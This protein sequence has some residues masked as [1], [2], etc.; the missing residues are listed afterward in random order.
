MHPVHQQGQQNVVGRQVRGRNCYPA[1]RISA[2]TCRM[3]AHCRQHF[4][5]NR[6]GLI[7]LVLLLAATAATAQPAPDAAE[8]YGG[9]IEEHAIKVD[10]SE[11]LQ[12][13]FEAVG[14]RRFVLL[15][16]SSHGT[17]EFYVWRDRITR[18]LVANKGFDFVAV[19]GDWQAI[20]RLNDYVTLR[21][22]HDNGVAGVMLESNSWP[23]WLWANEEFAAF[24]EW[25][26][27]HN[28]ALEPEQRVGLYGLDLQDPEDSARSVLAWFEQR[29]G[30]D[31]ERI[32]A[33]YRHFLDLPGSFHG[34]A[35][36]LAGGGERLADQAG[37]A[38]ELLNSDTDD[39]TQEHWQARHNAIAVARFERYIHDTMRMGATAGWNRR[40]EHFHQTLLALAERY[41]KQ[42]RA[43]V[44]AH[45]THI[46]DARATPMHGQGQ[47]NIG[48]LLRQGEGE[49]QVFI[50]G[51]STHGGKVMAARRDGAQ[52]EIFE[53]PAAR[54]DSVDGLLNA[55]APDQALL[56]FGNEFRQR[57][58]ALPLGHRAIGVTFN[59]AREAWVPSLL[60]WR[61]DA[62]IHINRSSA[63]N[64]LH[65]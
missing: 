16:E 26:R 20:R 5:A 51:F 56:L 7:G 46:G 42:S 11:H 53:L 15:G 34:Y 35:D 25:L 28:E 3:H 29:P 58:H 54:R 24:C 52:G 23:Q 30:D 10:S 1:D 63:L 27:A 18:R 43:A 47:L 6:P 61:Y 22:D 12:P 62:L 39:E 65:R 13:L 33:A 50:V 59:P 60:P 41:G 44:W 64:P 4:K 45:N 57:D 48:Q 9:L 49:E 14:Q 2:I 19:E 21:R 8:L 55:H 36:H 40:V 37:L 32:K 31:H 17:H 38:L